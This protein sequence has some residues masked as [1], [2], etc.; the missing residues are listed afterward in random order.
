M[1]KE[2]TGAVIE[3]TYGGLTDIGIT[4]PSPSSVET[5]VYVYSNLQD[6]TRR[7]GTTP[8][9][10]LSYV[11]SYRVIGHLSPELQQLL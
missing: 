7:Q 4:A 6:A 1:A 10:P 11:H 2:L 3:Y 8:R 5:E 9:M